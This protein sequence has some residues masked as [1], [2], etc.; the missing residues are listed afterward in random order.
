M[1]KDINYCS[2]EPLMNGDSIDTT[3]VVR[4]RM[5]PQG[6]TLIQKEGFAEVKMKDRPI[7]AV[8]PGQIASF[9]SADV[10]LASGFIL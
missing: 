8:A 4:N 10:L 1:I 3:V 6:C 5:E 9:Y 7:W 2:I